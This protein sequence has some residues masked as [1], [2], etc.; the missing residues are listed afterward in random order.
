MSRIAVLKINASRQRPGKSVL[1]FRTGTATICFPAAVLFNGN[2]RL[3]RLLFRPFA[4]GRGK[5]THLLVTPDYVKDWIPGSHAA[6][7]Q[8]K[9][10]IQ[11][12]SLDFSREHSLEPIWH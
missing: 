9:L 4:S 2:G 8:A 10:G 1:L 3:R 7:S 12:Q 11:S 6:K 5:Q